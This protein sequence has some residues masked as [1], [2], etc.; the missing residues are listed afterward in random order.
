MTTA[1][2]VFATSVLF[3]SRFW[4]TETRPTAGFESSQTTIFFHFLF[5]QKPRRK[6]IKSKK[7]QICKIYVFIVLIDF[8]L[9]TMIGPKTTLN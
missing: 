3:L 1:P 7:T 4:N 2:V 6:S 8:K 5:Y 9:T